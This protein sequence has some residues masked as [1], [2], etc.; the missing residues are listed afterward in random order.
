MQWLFFARALERALH[1]RSA[2]VARFDR[3]PR[4]VPL[5]MQ[6]FM[7]ADFLS[8][9]HHALK[10]P[11]R[12]DDTVAAHRDDSRWDRISTREVRHPTLPRRGGHELRGDDR[13]IAG[14]ALYRAFDRPSPCDI[15]ELD[16]A[17]GVLPRVL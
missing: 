9:S 10:R 13:V 17:R 8:R 16:A 1:D 7:S 15:R 5:E 14:F 6:R 11:S 4:V 3:A 2:H 12:H